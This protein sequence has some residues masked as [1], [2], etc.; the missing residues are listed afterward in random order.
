MQTSNL[1]NT[2]NR[3]I[4]VIEK[5]SKSHKATKINLTKYFLQRIFS[6]TNN[7]YAYYT[8]RHSTCSRSHLR[9]CT[10]PSQ[11]PSEHTRD[12]FRGKC[13]V[14]VSSFFTATAYRSEE[15]LGAPTP[16]QPSPPILFYIRG[17]R[18][19]NFFRKTFPWQ[20]LSPYVLPDFYVIKFSC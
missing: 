10:S 7:Y 18:E 14:I 11:K 12:R 1:Y 8:P 3:E 16:L 4:L 19:C 2:V 20:L 13:S 15:F 9:L 5:F 17:S 6:T